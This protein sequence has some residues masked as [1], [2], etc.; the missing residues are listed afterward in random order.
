MSEEED[1]R[2]LHAG[3]ASKFPSKTHES[4][5]DY[6]QKVLT[7][8][9]V[10]QPIFKIE[11]LFTKHPLDR[12]LRFFFIKKS[13]TFNYLKSAVFNYCNSVGIDLPSSQNTE[14]TNHKKLVQGQK[15]V[16][17]LSYRALA[18]ILGDLLGWFIVDI[19]ITLKNVSTDETFEMSLSDVEKVLKT[20]KDVYGKRTTNKQ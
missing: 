14:W 11:D 12:L 17:G 3:I 9:N 20:T 1:I 10:G 4:D 8:H 5:V 6:F 15:S 2:Q 13:I 7:S 18:F 16:F 19:K